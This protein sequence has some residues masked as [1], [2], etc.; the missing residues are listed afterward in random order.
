MG[1]KYLLRPLRVLSGPGICPRIAGSARMQYHSPLTS[2]SITTETPSAGSNFTDTVSS[3]LFDSSPTTPTV[4]TTIYDFPTMEPLEFAEYPSNHL[5]LPLRRDILH[6]AVVYE[7]DM[8]RQGTASTKWRDDV[9]GSGRKLYPQKGTGR[10]RAG[11]KK[12]PIRRGGG[13]AF[14]PKPRDF[15]TELPR[16]IYDLAW[17]TALSYRYRRGELLVVA[18]GADIEYP[19][20][21]FVKQIFEKNHWGNADG[22]SL[23]V[24]ESFR[25]NL[26][27]ALR[28]AGEEGRVLTTDQ[29]DVKDLL[30][31]GRVIIERSALDS[32]LREHQSDLLGGIRSVVAQQ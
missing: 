2:R 7:G 12:S 15:S 26:F 30:E 32:I 18:D 4:L 14:G 25:T 20:T 28:H 22:R 31:L 19:K 21:R 10:A 24:T 11:D 3:T 27:R 17:R 1:S 29:V 5:H 9:H 16:K 6:K 8:T 13:V 23:V